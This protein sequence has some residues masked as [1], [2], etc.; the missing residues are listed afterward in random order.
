MMGQPPLTFSEAL[1]DYREVKSENYAPRTWKAIWTHLERVRE[2]VS[3][4]NE[5]G[6]N[7]YLRE[8]D[9]R[10][11]LRYFNRQRPPIKNASTFNNYRQYSML[12]WRFAV[13]EGWVDRNPMRHVDPAKVT[14][15]PRLHLSAQDLLRMIEDATPRDRIAMVIAMNTGLRAMDVMRL[16]I[17]DVNL[18]NNLMSVFIAKT[19]SMDELPITAELRDELER[20]FESYAE[21]MG[22][23]DWR[24]DLP[25][26]WT[27][28]PPAQSQSRNVSNQFEGRVLTY[29]VH[30]TI[31]HPE[32]VVHRA[33]RK[34]NIET[35]GEGFHTL[36]RSAARV[37]FELSAEEG[38]RTPIRVA[39]AF[40]GHKE[41]KT[42]EIYLGLE[43]DKLARNELLQGKSFLGRAAQNEIATRDRRDLADS[44]QSYI[45]METRRRRRSA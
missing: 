44:T 25:N 27:L 5:L 28:V 9:E 15:R 35:K 8:V 6:P 12:F 13:E 41:Q 32:L 38:E 36:R 22:I 10:T 11:L 16:K 19:K 26:D 20:W 21:T 31:K 33:L 4:D 1:L 7:C 3:R 24:Y 43:S 18:G 39:M 34:M 17:S 2:F 29:R 37:V 23:A 40:L 42:T 14:R 45:D 30:D